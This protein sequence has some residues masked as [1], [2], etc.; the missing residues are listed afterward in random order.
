MALIW[1]DGDPGFSRGYFWT[2]VFLLATVVGI[3]AKAQGW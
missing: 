3:M 1:H 2:A